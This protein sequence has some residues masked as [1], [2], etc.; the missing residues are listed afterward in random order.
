MR[1]GD[2]LGDGQRLEQREVLEHHADAEPPRWA[3]LR[4]IDG[5]RLPIRC[6]RSPAAV[7]P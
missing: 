3:G 5:T 1:E 6:C 4:C 2:V 7:T